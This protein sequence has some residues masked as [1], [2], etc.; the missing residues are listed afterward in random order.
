MPQ[1]LLP[2]YPSDAT[3]INNV[4]SFCKRD[5]SFYYFHGAL[6]VFTYD[7][8]DIKAFWMFTSQLVVTGNCKQAEIVRTFGIT[9]IRMKRYLKMFRANGSKAFFTPHKKRQPRALTAE[10]LQCA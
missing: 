8:T 10:V 9:A 2:V 3:P 5:G 6:P 4:M 1:T 7:E